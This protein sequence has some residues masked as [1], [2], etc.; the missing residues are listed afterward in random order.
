MRLILI[1]TILGFGLP[2]TFPGASWETKTPSEL[3]L[4]SVKLA[5]VRGS[6]GG[7]GCIAKDGYMVMEWSSSSKSDWASAMKP[8][9]S[10]MLFFAVYEGKLQGI[11][12]LVDSV[13]QR[14]WSG[15]Q[16]IAK[17]KTM[18]FRHL[19][20]MVSGYALPE[21]PG[22]AWGYNDY[23]INLYSKTLFDGVFGQSPD[24]AARHA[25]RLGVLQFQDGSIF[26]SRSG[27]G[28]STSPRDFARIG[29]FWANKG[30]WN[31]RQILPDSFFTNYMKPDVPGSLPRTAG[32]SND[33]LNVYFTGGGTDQSEWGPGI[34]GFNW[35]FNGLVGTTGKRAWPDAPHDLI[36][37][38]GHWNRE[39][40]VIYPSLG[41]IAAARGNWGTLDPG[42]ANASM[43]RYLK[44]LK[45]AVLDTGSTPAMIKG[46]P[47]Q[48][49]LLNISPNPANA[50][51]KIAASGQRIADSDI[52]IAIYDIKGKM[53]HKLSATSY[54]LTAGITWT[55]VRMPAGVYMVRVIT[56]AQTFSRKIM[57]LR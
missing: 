8:V 21:A 2:P 18:T 4:D 32:G 46:P 35:W 14:L 22:A 1:L 7:V 44:L 42:N 24:A 33:Y 27:Y 6:V 43:N 54:Q 3:G 55:A 34:Y 49:A 52:K 23:A 10:T 15:K 17:D 51:I 53:V 38:N 36:M 25:D 31:G 5:Q 56:G 40:I 16:L 12:A 30:N 37:A 26:G 48:K 47:A 11:N 13:V 20:D 57:L 41:L 9:M 39:L 28:L 19:A 50:A 29:W 45:D